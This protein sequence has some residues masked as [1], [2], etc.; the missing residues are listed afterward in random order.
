MS[1]QEFRRQADIG[2]SLRTTGGGRHEGGIQLLGQ[3]GVTARRSMRQVANRP[4]ARSR[5]R[6]VIELSRRLGVD[7]AN[8]AI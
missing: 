3:G 1:D 5:P 7:S 2:H 4:P 8:M 6:E